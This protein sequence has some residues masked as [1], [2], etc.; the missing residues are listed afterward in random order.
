MIHVL[1]TARVWALVA[2]VLS[3]GLPAAAQQPQGAAQ[4]AQAP[5][6]PQADLRQSIGMWWARRRRHP[7]PG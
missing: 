3:L 6:A 1:R 4:P 5:A 2:A 7:S